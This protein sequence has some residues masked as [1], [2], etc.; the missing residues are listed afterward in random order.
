MA[1]NAQEEEQNDLSLPK[2]AGVL[3]VGYLAYR[4]RNN[5]TRQVKKVIG[6]TGVKLNKAANNVQFK[7]KM[8]E[9]KS[10]S[11][12][13]VDTYGVASP[14]NIARG[15]MSPE[16]RKEMLNKNL[17]AYN[18]GMQAR[19][20]NL[21][22]DDV[23]RG[24]ETMG[25]QFS[26]N[27]SMAK[28]EASLINMRKTA[29]G[30]NEKYKKAF[31]GNL[32]DIIQIFEE[33]PELLLKD[34]LKD[35]KFVKG[36]SG[37]MDKIDKP[38]LA[39]VKAFREY[40]NN[41]KRSIDLQ[42]DAKDDQLQNRFIASMMGLANDAYAKT[43]EQ[44]SEVGRALGANGGLHKISKGNS[45]YQQKNLFD[46]ST[47]E[48]LR[49]EMNEKSQK[50]FAKIMTENGMI[51]VTMEDAQSLT[52][53]NVN[54]K[55]FAAP[56]A[57]KGTENRQTISELFSPNTRVT[58]A[59]NRLSKSTETSKT[60]FASQYIEK[61]V[62]YGLDKK[63][64]GQDVFSN[65]L[66]IDP[67][68]SEILDTTGFGR[69]MS[70]MGDVFQENIQVPILN[71]NPL[72]LTQ[73]RSRKANANP[74][75][76]VVLPSGSIM[77]F[78]DQNKIDT[79]VG[80]DLKNAGANAHGT[81]RAY[82]AV[83]NNLIDSRLAEE[84]E[85]LSPPDAYKFY[86]AKV[87]DYIVEDN[88]RLVNQKTGQYARYGEVVSD[89]TN[90]E[91]DDQPKQ[92]KKLF[93]LGQESETL[94]GRVNR[95]ITK[96]DDPYYAE[97]ILDYIDASA[98]GIDGTLGAEKGMDRL[99]AT[100]YGKT[101][102]F[103]SNTREAVYDTLGNL[104]QQENPG[105]AN[106]DLFSMVNDEGVYDVA[107]QISASFKNKN[108][109][110]EDF[111]DTRSKIRYQLES[112]INQ[113]FT[114]K[115]AS[116]PTTFGD[117]QRYLK[118]RSIYQSDI[119]DTVTDSQLDGVNATEDLRKLIEQYGVS[120]A[121]E[122][123]VNL[124]NAVLNTEGIFEKKALEEIG[125]LRSLGQAGYFNTKAQEAVSLEAIVENRTNWREFYN[126]NTRDREELGVSIR[127]ADPWYG[128]G[129]GAKQE[130]LLGSG[131]YTPIKQHQG[132]L[133]SIN[134]QLSQ[135]AYDMPEGQKNS[136]SDA[137]AIANGLFDWVGG[138]KT[139]VAG[140]NGPITDASMFPWFM[141]NRLDTPLQDLGLGLP[142][143]L[144]G[145]ASSILFNQWSRR[146][147]LPYAAF[148]TA[149][150]FD[151]M[152]GDLASDTA[153]DAYVNMHQDVNTLKELTGI[154]DLGRG[155]DKMMPWLEQV[156]A[157]P[158]AKALNFATLGLFSD[159]RSGEEV[160]D[161]YESGED[162]IRKGRY[163][164]MGSNSPWMGNKI[165][166][167]EPNW[168]R[169]MKSD[170]MF[171]ENVYGS[172]KEYWANNWMPTLTNPFAPIKHFITDPYHYEEK[173][174]ESRPFAVT[175]GFNELQGIP[176]IGPAVDS[177]VSGIFK[178]T[179]VNAKLGKAHEEYLSS[180]N[181]RLSAAY[182][183]MNAGGTV[184][185]GPNGGI[186]LRSDSFNVNF[187]DEDGYL[188]EEA[189]VADEMSYN[190]ERDRMAISLMNDTGIIPQL[191]GGTMNAGMSVSA[192][193]VESLEGSYGK[194]NVAGLGTVGSGPSSATAS[195]L[196][197]Q[198]NA[199]LTDAK[200]TSRSDQ[201]SNAGTIGDPGR[202]MDLNDAVI[203]QDLTDPKGVLRDVTYNAGE[204]A[205]MYGFLSKTAFGFEES[206][207]GTT[208]QS[209][210]QFGSYQ[211]EF[212]DAE[213]GGLGGDLS[214]IGR[215][216]LPRDP[217]KDYYNPIRNTM[218][219]W[220]EKWSA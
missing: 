180:Y 67:D 98:T 203:Q 123:G 137:L 76:S 22:P 20:S 150:Y 53:E 133:A 26:K 204:M 208:L 202:L 136:I 216:Y 3:G 219:G 21:S 56:Q 59:S 122:K 148:Q 52:V 79:R 14:K 29:N 201:V 113:T 80:S 179:Q 23:V 2:L 69:L 57:A 77:A 30:S 164:G 212:W 170:Y 38:N 116:N 125:G 70:E 186:T 102:D 142:N 130:E 194:G 58:K 72:D 33:N 199:R 214:E 211:K 18:K 149:K 114:G 6:N 146:I 117:S 27:A 10:L 168:Y 189:L 163:W 166:R 182:I 13:V 19:L 71:M 15:L 120:L 8:D 25:S 46:I 66:F 198:M 97:N 109:Q 140:R 165:D 195:Y 153:A 93:G 99:Y 95:A 85:G 17:A 78:M 51:P 61:G 48:G 124:R 55:L 184:N 121:D 126:Q 167:Y 39:F 183:N 36:P 127:R 37:R 84:L 110:I 145:S 172:E 196:L 106:I 191:P 220:L 68:T 181:E 147:V 193:Q 81:N 152:T 86:Q 5:L 49:T 161:Y 143:H 112:Q 206:G 131:T 7:G 159:F 174:A 16:N 107:E 177:V 162:P 155:L 108:Q 188:D 35:S 4:N 190:A 89:R 32:N 94:Y 11:N 90:I 96:F 54:G 210:E 40:N 100:L 31:G 111:G 185:A 28:R 41:P 209:S 171:S 135:A 73:R 62:R 215:R 74:P 169:K 207:R 1:K 101:K 60:D 160:N 24:A 157:L 138:A 217:N 45:Y 91:L 104:I 118:S 92:L 65:H 141:A 75:S 9:L 175:G 128:T 87:N 50:G 139:Y 12:A 178:P 176:L 63:T 218:P 83:N 88:V 132:P 34:P 173:L 205:G 197:G 64:I 151:G 134:K 43:N 154:N 213:L 82:V 105:I 42:I 192:E 156:E 200:T 144:K 187:R 158:G 103:S 44:V 47:F 119:V 129:A 115:Y